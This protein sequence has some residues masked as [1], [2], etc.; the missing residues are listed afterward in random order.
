MSDALLFQGLATSFGLCA[1]PNVINC[2]ARFDFWSRREFDP[3]VQWL[4]ALF[5][6]IGQ[7]IED[8]TTQTALTVVWSD[9]NVDTIKFQS[10]VSDVPEP[11]G[12]ILLLSIL[13]LVASTRWSGPRFLRQP[14]NP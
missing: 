1:A 7:V 2:D 5:T 10:D 11:S 13:F 12:L 14:V 8:G 9:G 3:S 4:P 6:S